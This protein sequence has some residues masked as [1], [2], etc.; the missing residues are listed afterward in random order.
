[1][2]NRLSPEVLQIVAA[3]FR[4]LADPLRL[5]ILQLLR[6]DEYSVGGIADTLEMSQPNVSKHLKV[7]Q[8][9]GLVT[10]RQEG[11]TAWYSGGDPMVDK[12]CDLVC[13]S[14]EQQLEGQRRVLRSSRRAG[15]RSGA[16]PRKSDA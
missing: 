9:A 16:A 13:E 5:R 3:R 12:L 2:A 6:D 11:T 1:M 4:V 10:R 7:L 14:I 15:S 8:E